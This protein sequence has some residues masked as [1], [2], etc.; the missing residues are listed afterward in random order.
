MSFGPCGRFLSAAKT[1]DRK[2]RS[3]KHS[4]RRVQRHLTFRLLTFDQF[5][6]TS[7]KRL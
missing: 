1:A 2:L 5:I 7:I 6:V 4:A 3:N